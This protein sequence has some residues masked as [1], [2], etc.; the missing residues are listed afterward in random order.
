MIKI[1]YGEAN[2]RK[3]RKEKNLY[4]DKTRYIEE[5]E[6]KNVSRGLF[7]RPRR[8]GKSLWI[9]TLWHYY[10]E[11]YKEE[12]DELFGDLYI[13]QHP[14][15]L[16]NSYKILF[17]E[18]SGIEIDNI[19][20]V[21]KRFNRKVKNAVEFF[22][23]RYQVGEQAM[24]RIENLDM[25]EDVLDEF[26]KIMRDEKIYVLIDEYDHFANGILAESMDSFLEIVG[27]GGFVRT[28]YEVIKTGAMLGVFDRIFIT[29]VTPITMDSLSSGFN[30]ANNISL[31][32]DFNE[33]CGFTEEEVEYLLEETVFQEC[34]EVD[35]AR[36][37]EDVRKFYNGYT[38]S[39]ES[40]T[41]VYNATLINYFLSK[42]N[43]KRCEYPFQLLDSNIAT[44]YRK[45]MSLFGIGDRETNYSLL[46]ELVIEGETAGRIKERYELED[47]F[48]A[49]DFLTLLFSL[50]F[51]TL[52][53]RAMGRYIFQ[54]PNYVIRQLYFEYF[55]HELDRRARLGINSRE[56]DNALYELGLGKIEKFVKEVDRVIKQMS[57]RDFR[58]FEEKH[59]KAIVL[60]LLSYMDYYYIKSEAEVSGKYPDIMLLKRNPFEEEIKSEYLFEL[61][62]ARQG[63]EEK[64]L[65]EGREQVKKY[66]CSPEIREKQDMKFYVL[67]GS[68]AGVKAFEML[69]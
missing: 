41:K 47:G 67:V 25:A 57:N 9:S 1:P 26:L 16:R 59:F 31:E 50:G 7:L 8:F 15:P 2:F 18:F 13:G 14:T 4:I 62:W 68:K 11:Y 48:G 12:F 43:Y 29:G 40:K 22:I 5:L 30:I 61:K 6:K 54:I 21:R 38:F 56:L 23:Q 44:D 3:L 58:Q 63:E 51:I 10:D 49:D 17:M 39:P 28:F 45:L 69:N 66:M 27:K 33:M 55:R 36:V 46:E 60:S 19:Q 24:S 52:K 64:R 32:E 34:S 42:F 53:S 35:K 37:R 20:A 65:Q